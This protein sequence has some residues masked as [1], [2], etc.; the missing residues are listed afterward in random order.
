MATAKAY[1]VLFKEKRCLVPADGWFE[2]ATIDGRKQPH[3]MT[4]P[5]G[6]AFA[7]LWAAGRFGLSCSIITT[8]AVGDLT[9]DPKTGQPRS[10]EQAQRPV[11]EGART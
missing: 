1:A 4:L 5:E 11:S 10:L 8:P 9:R 3:F 6:F 7:G 2:W